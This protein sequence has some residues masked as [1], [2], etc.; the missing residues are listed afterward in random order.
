VFFLNSGRMEEKDKVSENVRACVAPSCFFRGAP[1]E[2]VNNI[3]KQSEMSQPK[4][5]RDN[6]TNDI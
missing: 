5:V 6:K 2:A 3:L 4:V 1:P